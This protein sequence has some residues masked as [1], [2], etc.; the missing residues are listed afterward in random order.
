[1]LFYVGDIFHF[2]GDNFHFRGDNFHFRVSNKSLMSFQYRTKK[3]QHAQQ[4]NDELC[5]AYND[6]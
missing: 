3:V 1:M 5:A 2:R 4:D 6:W